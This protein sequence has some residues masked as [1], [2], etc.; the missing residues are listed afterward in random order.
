M[1]SFSFRHKEFVTHVAPQL[2]R[3]P[4]QGQ[5]PTS[6]GFKSQWGLKSQVPQDNSKE[7]SSYST[8]TQ[9]LSVAISSRLSAEGIGK[10]AHLPVSPWTGLT[11]CFLIC[12]LRFWL[13]ISLNV[14]ADCD[15]PGSLK[16]VVGI[17]PVVSPHSLQA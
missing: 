17:S 12:C 14:G 10:N 11:A 8:G 5:T 6:P 1:P 4:L 15:L 9:A 2:I 16:E 13:L 7:R 3:L